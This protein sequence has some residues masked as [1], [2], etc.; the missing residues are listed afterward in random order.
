VAVLDLRRL[1]V[2]LAVSRTGT[3]SGAARELHYGQPT[4]SHHLRRLEAETGAV[5]LQR[6]G[7]GVRLTA[8]GERLATRAAELIGLAN[9]AETELVNAT[10]LQHG[11]VRLTAFPSA[12]ATLLPRLLA[13]LAE[14]HRGLVLELTEAEP[15]E[16]IALLRAGE[17]D[18]CLGFTYPGEVEDDQLTVTELLADPLHLVTDRAHGA[19]GDL[20]SYAEARWIT[21]CERCR[22]ELLAL[23]A[24]A[25]FEPEV[26]FATDDYVAVQAMVAA[27][28][29][30]SV[31]PGLAVQ[32]HRHDGVV[33]TPLPG[34]FRQVRLLGYGRPPLP[35]AVQLVVDALVADAQSSSRAPTGQSAG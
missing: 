29:G 32:A 35:P 19:P 14:R 31:L 10:K 13:L 3:V 2:L 7:R 26:V 11:T 30:V 23:C 8:E 22:H 15:P 18:L 33:L 9:R 1:E 6:V 28:L 16:G 20:A 17:T 25:G 5:L 24:E 21:G 34:A 12:T 27:G 4:V